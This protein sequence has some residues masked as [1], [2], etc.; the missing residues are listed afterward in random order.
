[1][2]SCLALCRYRQMHI[3]IFIDMYVYNGQNWNNLSYKVYKRKRKMYSVK[4]GEDIVVKKTVG[5]LFQSLDNG[6]YLMYKT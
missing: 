3:E 6:Q 2:N 4:F 1:M 5:I